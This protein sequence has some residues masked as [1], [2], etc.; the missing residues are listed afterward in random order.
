MAKTGSFL[1]NVSSIVS[2]NADRLKGIKTSDIERV[3]VQTLKDNVLNK[4]YFVEETAEYFEQLK[5]DI[6][7]R[8]IIV[9]LIAKEDG[10]LLAG[11]NRLR[12]AK[13]LGYETVPVQYVLENLPDDEERGFLVKDNLLRRQLT[14]EQKIRLY[15][16]LYP[17]FE[18]RFLNPDVLTKAGRKSKDDT[19][20]TLE[21]VARETGQSVSAVKV[22][23]KR[24][25][26]AI[27]E[28][29]SGHNAHG[30]KNNRY[31]VTISGDDLEANGKKQKPDKNNRYNVTI[32]GS[33]K[34]SAV[35]HTAQKLLQEL[36][37]ASKEE[38][39]EVLALLR[40]VLQTT[41]S[42]KKS[43]RL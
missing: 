8:G 9:P 27:V 39:E 42:V 35:M 4:K 16:M 28:Q 23:V 22:Q 5:K 41:T 20:L 37:Q 11:H 14:N 15:K 7:Q 36:P 6:E 3:S 24:K 21:Q 10:T 34:V 32:S 43:K 30:K 13:E 1:K 31:N 29:A 19:S 2:K 25:R 26:D 38:Q 12:V 17:E 33:K 40:T 18:E